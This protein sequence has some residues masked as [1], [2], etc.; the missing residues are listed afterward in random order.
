MLGRCG[1]LLVQPRSFVNEGGQD[2]EE[3]L[4]TRIET[5]IFRGEDPPQADE[6]CGESGANNT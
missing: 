6:P 2:P 5:A 1:F 3:I 4:A